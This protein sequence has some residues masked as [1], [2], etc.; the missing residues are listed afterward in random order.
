MPRDDRHKLAAL[1]DKLAGRDEGGIIPPD[2]GAGIDRTP[3]EWWTMAK[4][5]QDVF[6]LPDDSVTPEPKPVVKVTLNVPEGVEL[7]L[8]INGDD[9][10]LGASDH[11]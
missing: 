10:F 7:E 1:L 4:P 8:T 11:G 2:T 3:K 9:V 6:H 5:P